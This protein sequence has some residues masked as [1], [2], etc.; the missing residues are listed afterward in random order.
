MELPCTIIASGNF[1]GIALIATVVLL[2]LLLIAVYFRSL[3]YARKYNILQ[4]NN[5]ALLDHLSEVEELCRTMTQLGKINSF[6]GIAEQS[7]CANDDAILSALGNCGIEINKISPADRE[8][9]LT[10][11]RELFS[12]KITQFTQNCLL[13]TQPPRHFVISAKSFILPET[14]LRKV[15]FASIDATEL[16][17]QNKEL[18]DAD[19]ILQAIFE[20]LPGHIFI[21]NISD[22]FAYVRCSPSYSQL[23]QKNPSDFVGKNDFDLFDHELAQAIRT[24]DIK[25]A[26]TGQTADNRWFFTTPDGKEHITRFISRRLQRADNSEWILGFGLDITRQE[27]IA[28]KLRRRNKELR[29]LMSQSTEAAFLLDSHLN[30]SCATPQMQQYILACQLAGADQTPGCAELCQ[31]GITDAD[32][33]PAHNALQCNQEQICRHIR[34]TGKQ[35]QIKPLLNENGIV[36]YLAVKLKDAVDETDETG[37]EEA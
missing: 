13:Q 10:Q 18:A 37:E 2:L 4:E 8:H 27:Q 16:E 34:Y 23:I 3:K 36:N 31:C 15:L 21:R 19:S 33:C 24:V 29:L 28:I 20:N 1:W 9:Y 7:A 6:T 26:N 11:S 12:G 35:L 17:Q 22:D 5:S 14:G 25:I 32:Q 30:L